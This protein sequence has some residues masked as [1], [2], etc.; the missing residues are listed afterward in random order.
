MSIA[1]VTEISSTSEVSFDDAVAR[2]IERA[3]KSLRHLKSA[4][5]KESN[6]DISDGKVTAYRVNMMVTFVL[7]E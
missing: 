6:V 2:G 1:K 4:W 5:I 3:S 7:D